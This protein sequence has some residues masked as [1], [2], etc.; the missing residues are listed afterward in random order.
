[1]EILP[2]H[3]RIVFALG[4]GACRV[5]TADGEEE[6]LALYEGLAHLKNNELLILSKN[7]ETAKEIDINRCEEA[8]RRIKK[9]RDGRDPELPPLKIDKKRMAAAE[10]RARVRLEIAKEIL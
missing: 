10:K 2:H 4:V 1:M 8:L 7:S 9:R 3:G 6:K 5:L